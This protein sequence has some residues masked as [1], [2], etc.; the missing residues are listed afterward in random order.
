MRNDR[1]E[2]HDAAGVGPYAHDDAGL[3][4]LSD[5]DWEIADGSADIRGWEVR[6]LGGR[7]LGRVQDLLVDPEL[8]QVVSMVIDLRGTRATGRA[9]IRAAEIDRAAKV[10]RLDSADIIGAEAVDTE[11]RDVERE[12]DRT[13]RALADREEVRD[14]RER[15]AASDL[16]EEE[17][18]ERRPVVYE[19][20][21]VRR[22]AAKEG[23]TPQDT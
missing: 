14:D 11:D 4:S 7:E 2:R 17:V 12:V 19:E 13:P 20:I 1:E 21:V 18:I 22:R 23:D 5:L 16:G 9:S 3:K 15:L 6:T 10:V 8:R